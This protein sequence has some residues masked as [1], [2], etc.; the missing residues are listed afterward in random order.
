M[1][2]GASSGRGVERSGRRAVG[3][4]GGRAC[5]GRA[6]ARDHNETMRARSGEAAR[7]RPR[8]QGR[9][10]EAWSRRRGGRG[11]GE[12]AGGAHAV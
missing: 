3:L 2:V 8:A 6:E 1:A 7:S 12:E 11:R 5:R 4:A 9:S 10:Q